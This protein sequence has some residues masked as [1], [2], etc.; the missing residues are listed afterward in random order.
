MVDET[1]NTLNQFTH[2]LDMSDVL[3]DLKEGLGDKAP[4][5]KVNLLNWIG[6]HVD[7]K[8]QEKG[9]VPDKTRDGVK[10][11]FPNFEKLLEDGIAEV[12]EAMVRT[13]AKLQLLLGEDFLAPIKGKVSAK[14][15][16]KINSKVQEK[17]DTQE[18]SSKKQPAQDPQMSKS[19]ISAK[20][21]KAND[22]KVNLNKTVVE[23]KQKEEEKA[24]PLECFEEPFFDES[25]QA[26]IGLGMPEEQIK[27]VTANGA[28]ERGSVL[29]YF[30]ENPYE[31]FNAIV[32]VIRRVFK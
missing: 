4:N 13:V 18:R 28:N 12:R 30:K 32:R 9:E 3:D 24:P 25:L 23:K 1:F 14:V 8:A 15:A 16:S 19:G 7:L 11:L 2:C 26:L 31:N 29:N 22:S 5:M 20:G 27:N 6:K 21:I 17:Q 10:K